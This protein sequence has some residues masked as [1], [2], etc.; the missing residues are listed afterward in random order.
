VPHYP[1][2]PSLSKHPSA[3]LS[4]QPSPKEGVNQ[5][6]QYVLNLQNSQNSWKGLQK[7]KSQNISYQSAYNGPSR[8]AARLNS[9]HK[10]M[11]AKIPGITSEAS[12]NGS[13]AVGINNS[14]VTNFSNASIRPGYNPQKLPQ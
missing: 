8:T 6:N 12:Q 11:R 3:K 7:T 5:T 2:D 14:M 13:M 4:S 10:I 1:G 9:R